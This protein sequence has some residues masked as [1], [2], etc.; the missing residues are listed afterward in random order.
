MSRGV[1]LA[2]LHQRRKHLFWYALGLVSY[3]WFMVWFWPQMGGADY[4]AIVDAMPKELFA[5]FG[6]AELS[7]ASLGGFFQT[8]YLGLMWILIASSAVIGYAAKALAG[9]IS[10]G[11]MELEMSQPVSRTAFI[12][13]RIAVLFVYVA[14]VVVATFL[15]IQVFGPAYEIDLPVRTYALLYGIGSLFLLSIGA[16]ALLISA[17][18]KDGGRPVAVASALIAVMW[19]G[20]FLAQVSDVADALEPINLLGYWK[21]GRLINDGTASGDWWWVYA[22]VTVVALAGS[23][24]VFKRRDLA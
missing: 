24:V 3:S 20:D 1:F 5:L 15:P 22:L 6:D 18:S 12:S 8:E 11:T 10:S 16:V 7:F 14:V 21:P 23:V 17:L 13:T 2:T 9:E 19:M 4:A